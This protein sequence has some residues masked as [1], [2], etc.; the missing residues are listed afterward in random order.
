MKLNSV[1]ITGA[2]GDIGR[3]LAKIVGDIPWIN[4]VYGMDVVDQFPAPFFY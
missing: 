2:A 4:K 1:L 3:G